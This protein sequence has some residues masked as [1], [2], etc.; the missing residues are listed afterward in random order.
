MNQSIG[1]TS[2]TFRWEIRRARPGTRSCEASART[3]KISNPSSR[4][5]GSTRSFSWTLGTTTIM[6]WIAPL[7]AFVGSWAGELGPLPARLY[8]LYRRVKNWYAWLEKTSC[9][10][11]SAEVQYPKPEHEKEPFWTGYGSYAAPGQ[12]GLFD[13]MFDHRQ[14]RSTWKQWN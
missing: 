3:R 14:R 8:S 2:C 12:E 5:K 7:Q 13:H 1:R 10:S 4:T 9:F 6:L 11:A